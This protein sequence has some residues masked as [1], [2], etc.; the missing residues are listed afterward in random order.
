VQLWVRD[1]SGGAAPHAAAAIDLSAIAQLPAVELGSGPVPLPAAPRHSCRLELTR[2]LDCPALSAAPLLLDVE[3]VRST[4]YQ[5]ACCNEERR[6]EPVVGE[7]G[8]PK[9]PQ[10]KLFLESLIVLVSSENSRAS[11]SGT[12]LSGRKPMSG[13]FSV[14]SD[15]DRRQNVQ[16]VARLSCKRGDSSVLPSRISNFDCTL[17]QSVYHRTQI[18]K[19]APDEQEFEGSKP[20]S[21]SE[22]YGNRDTIFR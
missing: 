7:Q 22:G 15:S 1:V 20:T 18:V 8:E 9:A 21:H 16:R 11:I 17:N 14:R 12:A 10:G 2:V 5:D 3:V 6:A 13:K 19:H 4:A